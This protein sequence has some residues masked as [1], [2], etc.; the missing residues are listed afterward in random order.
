[1]ATSGASAIVGGN[2][3]IF[4]E[5][6]N[7][8]GANIYLNTTVSLFSSILLNFASILFS[9]DQDFSEVD[10]LTYMDGGEHSGSQR[11]RCCHSCCSISFICDSCSTVS[12]RSSAGA[13]IHSFACNPTRYNIPRAQPRLF[14]F[15]ELFIYSSNYVDDIRRR[16]T[17]RES[18]RI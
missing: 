18:T 14:C 12:L 2:F 8:S 9:G 11:L 15:V 17:W 13:T 4:E 7:H 1:M 10:I 16:Q 6:L 5:F 3:Q